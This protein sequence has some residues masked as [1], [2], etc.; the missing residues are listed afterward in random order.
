MNTQ[1]PTKRAAF[2]L[3]KGGVG[4]T[5]LSSAF[6]RE[7]AKRGRKTLIVSLDPAHNLGDVFE[8]GLVDEPQ[9]IAPNLDGAEID[10]AAWVARYLDETKRE[11]KANYSYQ[12]VLNMD[13]FLNIMKYS[14]G[15]EEYAVLWA[16]EHI[17]CGV[18]AHYDSVVF[19]T[20][21]TALSLRFLAL[22]TISELWVAELTK[23]RASILSKR[24]TLLKLNPEAPVANSCVDKSEDRVYGKL[25]AIQK[26]LGLLNEVFKKES[27]VAVVVNPDILS[28]SEAGKIREELERL[29]IPIGAI[30]RNKVGIPG[31]HAEGPTK[32]LRDL[33]VFDYQ[34]VSNGIRELKTLDEL[35]IERIAD[36]YLH[37]GSP[38]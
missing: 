32:V 36:H 14:P 23:L 13:G 31:G 7:L 38:A 35:D 26:R 27:F 8:R 20:P 2:F 12:S 25:D 1:N 15:T 30:C 29:G 18:G 3:G 16:I 9:H 19:D 33:P 22:P 5:T 11:I 4:K 21:P 6:A 17:W 10:L 24:S 28:M 37:T 34:L